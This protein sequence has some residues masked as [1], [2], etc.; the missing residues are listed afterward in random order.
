[1]ANT[2]K[3]S[4]SNSQ[5]VAN[6]KSSSRTRKTKRAPQVQEPIITAPT[7]QPK[8]IV[9]KRCFERWYVYF[10]GVRPA[11]NVGCGCKTAKSALRYMQLLKYRYG[12]VIS[13]NIYER[14]QFEASKE[15]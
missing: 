1:M 5:S 14:L 8:L 4:V 10:Q 6:K 13:T 12:A 7:V 2:A 9:A 3:N 11:D 15:A